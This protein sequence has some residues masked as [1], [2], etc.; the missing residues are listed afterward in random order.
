MLS[1]TKTYFDNVLISFRPAAIYYTIK[2]VPYLERIFCQNKV[3]SQGTLIFMYLMTEERILQ[4]KREERWEM[5][6]MLSL[7][8]QMT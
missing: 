7:S 8:S 1:L 2:T 4:R 6:G 5:S 3:L